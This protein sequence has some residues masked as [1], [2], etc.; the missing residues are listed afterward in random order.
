MVARVVA[1]SNARASGELLL[2]KNCHPGLHC[3]V[4][5]PDRMGERPWAGI[6]QS[7][8]GQTG[9]ELTSEHPG[10]KDC[11]S[12]GSLPASSARIE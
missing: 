2:P 11:S 12:C 8:E 1:K 5:H 6:Y 10:L 4:S 3:Q 7:D 9:L